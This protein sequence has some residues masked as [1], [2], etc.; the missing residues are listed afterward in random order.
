MTLLCRETPEL[1]A[2]TLFSAIEIAT[3]VHFECNRPKP[4]PDNLSRA[5]LTLASPGRYLNCKRY[6][7]PGHQVMWVPRNTFQ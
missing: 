5:L 4:P 3:P 2:E 7:A 6:A 1:S